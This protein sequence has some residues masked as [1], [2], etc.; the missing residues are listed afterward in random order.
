ML[1]KSKRDTK[2]QR[3]EHLEN[4]NAEEK[5]HLHIW[6]VNTPEQ[7]LAHQ[8]SNTLNQHIESSKIAI[9]ELAKISPNTLS[10]Y[11][12]LSNNR[13]MGINEIK[14]KPM[15]LDTLKSINGYLNKLQDAKSYFENPPI[16]INPTQN[17]G[18]QYFK[19]KYYPRIINTLNTHAKLH[20]FSIKTFEILHQP[21]ARPGAWS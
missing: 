14:D 8:Y 15:L 10:L 12:E 4:A 11:A 9:A 3:S 19:E 5:E 6:Q 18:L 17:E 20:A 1:L 21:T 2:N 16:S 13:Y 7:E